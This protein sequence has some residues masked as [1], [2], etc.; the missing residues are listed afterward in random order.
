MAVSKQQK[1]E[2]VKQYGKDAKDTGNTEVQIAILTAEIKSLTEHLKDNTKDFASKRTL[3]AKNSKRRSLLNYLKRTN[4]E[5]YRELVK[6]LD[7]R[8]N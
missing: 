4:L 5:K 6:K 7:L 2:L 1:Q 8:A 3:Y